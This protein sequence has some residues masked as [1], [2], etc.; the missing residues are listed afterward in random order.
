MVRILTITNWYPP[1][2][3]GGYELSCFD[4]MTRLERRGHHVTVLCGDTRMPGAAPP[5]DPDHEGR[6]RRRLRLYHDGR[7]LLRPPWRERWAIERHNRRELA[8]AVAA[9]RPDVISVWHLAGV[10]HGLL[11]ELSAS[12]IPVVLAV[13]DDWLVYGSKLDAWIAPFEATRA[14]R[15]LGRVV[16]RVTG[17]ACSVADIGDLGA[18]LFVSEATMRTAEA[19]SR[20]TFARSAVVWSG[21]DRATY[22][23]ASA[24]S[25]EPPTDRPWRWRLVT[26]G[27]FDPRKGFDTAVEALPLL[28]EAAT[29]SCWGR[30]GDD[31]VARL[32]ELASSLAV[33]DRVRF[34]SFEREE[35]P[36]AY[37]AADVMVFPST[38]PEPFGLV[39]VEAMACGTPVVAT[40]VGGSA[41]FLRHEE[42][43]LLVPPGDPVA[44]AAAIRRLAE[45]PGLRERLVAEG[46]RTADLLD[47]DHL[48]DVM[49]AWHLYE[50]GGRVGEEPARRP[51]V[52]PWAAAVRS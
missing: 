37:R 23:A 16:G 40:G 52:P 3:L 19:R 12:G 10:S 15:A 44:L 47:V 27:R 49:E 30:G 17:V 41:E 29:L 21:I 6:V 34:G 24:G 48:A 39:P 2:H 25:A 36:E 26:S 43:C 7:D 9:A 18:F 31:E 22:P 28:P 8:A 32:R 13:C 1:H 45:D 5:P 50:A 4:V 33:S 42:N 46:H 51:G 11:A 38:W 35:L 14:R 20:W